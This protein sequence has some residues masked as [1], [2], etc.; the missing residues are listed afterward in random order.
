[1]TGMNPGKH[2]VYGFTR[3]EPGDGYSIKVN[4]GSTRRMPSVWQLLSQARRRSIVLNVPMTYPPQPIDGIVVTGID[5]PALESQFTYP[6]AFRHDVLGLVPDYL[7]DV[8]SWGVEAAGGRRKLLFEDI[9]RMV[10][11][12]RRMALH[13]METEMWDLF[14]VVFTATDRAMHFFWRF[15]DPAHPL[16]D[17][18]EAPKYHDAI[19][20]VYQLVDQALGEVL[21]NLDDETTLIVMSDHGFGPQLKLFRINQWLIENG[22][23]HMNYEG[24]QGLRSHFSS[25]AKVWMYDGLGTMIGLLRAN[26]SSTAKDRLKR[27]FPNLR[28]RVGSQVL[29]TGVDWS[30][31]KAY[32]TAEF[33]GS[34]RVNMKGRE[35]NGRVEPGAEYD[36]VCAEIQS[37][38]E[39]CIDPQTGQRI[40][41]QVFRR[42]DL[43]EGPFKEAAPDLIVQL[44]DYS[45]T[46]DWF[47]QINRDNVRGRPPVID[48]LAGPFASNCGGHR[49]DGIFMLYGNDLRRGIET[50]RARIYDVVPTALYLM[51]LAIPSNMDGE[52]L[53]AAIKPGLLDRRP[54]ERGTPTSPLGKL[55]YADTYT[56]ED[57]QT[58]AERLHDLGYL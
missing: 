31:T 6:A 36:E 7:L 27:L 2:G 56:E 39:G 55:A 53:T 10:E 22:F 32:H 8:H 16:Y 20:Q 46:I 24:S 28:E 12:R 21:A 47:M 48:T 33:P 44:A 43:Y 9:K 26:L 18:A 49:Q 38:L 34:I 13:L 19:L 51:G 40:V 11:S 3:V 37:A 1:M 15:L 45:Y 4:N 35:V 25:R 50:D 41:Q 57:A 54:V 52:V 30:R 58:V 17:A 5:T 29:F 14:T 23:L 42:D